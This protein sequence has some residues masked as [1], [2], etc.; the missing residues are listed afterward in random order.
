MMERLPAV[1][2][3]HA[4]KK[5]GLPPV[6]VTFPDGLHFDGARYYGCIGEERYPLALRSR[7]R[8][9]G[10]LDEGNRLVAERE[11][12]DALCTREEYARWRAMAA[13]GT[14]D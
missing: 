12:A 14:P 11:E 5:H 2:T 9:E 3:F 6:T 8:T 10:R 7:P 1:V 4:R 13:A